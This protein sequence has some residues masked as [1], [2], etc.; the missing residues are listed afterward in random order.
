MGITP[1]QK[2][3]IK[4]WREKNPARIQAYNRARQKKVNTVYAAL[5]KKYPAIFEELKSSTENAIK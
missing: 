1:A 4:T 2:R 3:A 5:K